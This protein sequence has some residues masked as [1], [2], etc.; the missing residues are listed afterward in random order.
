MTLKNNIVLYTRFSTKDRDLLI[1]THN[2][3]NRNGDEGMI[4][5][6]GKGEG[7]G[8]KKASLFIKNM[9]V[10]PACEC[11]LGVRNRSE[12]KQVHVLFHPVSE[13]TEAISTQMV[14]ITL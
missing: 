10:F 11:K 14:I 7:N 1:I 12:S 2:L 6:I 3:H 9:D 13:L 8:G 5:E 4:V